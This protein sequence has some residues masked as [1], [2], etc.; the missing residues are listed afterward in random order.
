MGLP[1]YVAMD[2]KPENGC[3]LQNS[4]D[5]VSGVMMRL[6]LAKTADAEAEAMHVWFVL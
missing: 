3:E 5:G 2:R 4:A 1:H 6:K